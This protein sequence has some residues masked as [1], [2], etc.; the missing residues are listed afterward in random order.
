MP[1]TLENKKNDGPHV[2]PT[3]HPPLLSP[4]SFLFFLLTTQHRVERASELA[5]HPSHRPSLLP[6]R[7]S[8]PASPPPSLAPPPPLVSATPASPLLD[9]HAFS[10][11]VSCH[12][13]PRPL[14]G[15]PPPLP[16]MATAGALDLDSKAMA[17]F[18]DDD[19]ELATELYTQAI[20]ASPATAEL[21]ADRA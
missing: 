17:A 5:S 7:R 11:S 15:S 3:C 21:Y 2:G 16:P 8:P 6:L 4:S 20:E 19:F 18:V 14:V 1:V 12:R 10:L 13:P 9:D